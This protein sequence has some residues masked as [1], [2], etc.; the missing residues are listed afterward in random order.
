[1]L[2]KKCQFQKHVFFANWAILSKKKL[3][4]EKFF[5]KIF[6]LPEL[7]WSRGPLRNSVLRVSEVQGSM[8]LRGSSFLNL[9]WVIETG[10]EI[11]WHFEFIYKVCSTHSTLGKATAPA[12]TSQHQA[13]A[14][15]TSTRQQH[16]HQAAAPPP[17]RSNSKHCRTYLCFHSETDSSNNCGYVVLNQRLRLRKGVKDTLRNSHHQVASKLGPRPT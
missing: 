15:G 5:H 1:M 8:P 6:C 3:R 4:N 16:Q 10:C 9:V 2:G 13:T 7:V 14:P 11:N 17:P 12:S